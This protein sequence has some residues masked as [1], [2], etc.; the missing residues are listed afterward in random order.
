MVPEKDDLNMTRQLQMNQEKVTKQM[1]AKCI[2]C[3]QSINDEY[4]YFLSFKEVSSHIG[5]CHE[6]CLRKIF[7]ILLLNKL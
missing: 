6:D 2:I 7:D 5:Y 4:R 3:N 1:S